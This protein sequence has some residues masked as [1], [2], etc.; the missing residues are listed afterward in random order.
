MP[1]YFFDLND[2]NYQRD[3]I[4]SDLPD[5]PSAEQDATRLL[6]EIIRYEPQR[7]TDRGLRV[8]VREEEHVGVCTV[9][10]K[11]ERLDTST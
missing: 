3:H 10:A 5:L 7:L 2:D 1:R 11:L 4:G 9:S 8:T 6:G